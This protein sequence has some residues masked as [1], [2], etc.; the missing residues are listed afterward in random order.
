M[1][2]QAISSD[3]KITKSGRS[4]PQTCEHSCDLVHPSDCRGWSRIL[5]TSNSLVYCH[6][7]TSDRARRRPKCEYSDWY[8]VTDSSHTAKV[9]TGS[10]PYICLILSCRALAKRMT[11][12]KFILSTSELGQ[13]PVFVFANTS[14]F[15]FNSVVKI[16]FLSLFSK[17]GILLPRRESIY[18]IFN[19]GLNK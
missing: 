2:G 8:S 4:T 15:L 12:M 18:K 17:M 3:V 5:D 14:S 16:F 13:K 1:R 7:G 10:S 19:Y 6:G 9:W 11:D